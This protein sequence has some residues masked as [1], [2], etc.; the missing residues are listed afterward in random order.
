MLIA[1]FLM[2]PRLGFGAEAR[3]ADDLRDI[4]SELLELKQDRLRDREEIGDLKAR[5]EQLEGE[6]KQLKATN[7]QIQTEQTQTTQAVKQ[8]QDQSKEGPSPS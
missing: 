3:Q 4:K 2:I 5:V 7:N 6:N 8:I 1:G